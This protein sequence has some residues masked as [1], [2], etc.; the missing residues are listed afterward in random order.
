MTAVEVV[1]KAFSSIGHDV[2]IENMETDQSREGR[3]ARQFYQTTLD[4]LAA[5]WDWPFLVRRAEAQLDAD[6]AVTLPED[7]L[8]VITLRGREGKVEAVRRGG[9]L[10]AGNS[11]RRFPGG[12]MLDF[13]T[14]DFEIDDTPVSF[15]V[16]FIAAL[17]EALVAPLTRDAHRMKLAGDRAQLTKNRA[18]YDAGSDQRVVGNESDAYIQARW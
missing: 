12:L 18:Q 10:W 3:L 2:T 8:R 17:A 4:M 5:G 14:R 6:G 1:N 7:C 9:K 16:A 15:Q 11:V 13:I